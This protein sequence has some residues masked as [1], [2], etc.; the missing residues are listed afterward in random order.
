MPAYPSLEIVDLPD[1]V[2]PLSAGFRSYNPGLFS[3]GKRQFIAFRV[4]DHTICGGS[5]QRTRKYY[6]FVRI[7]DTASG[8]AV[9]VRTTE[10]P[11][12]PTSHASGHED[13]RPLVIGSEVWLF[14][15]CST[16]GAGVTRMYLQRITVKDLLGAFEDGREVQA[17][18]L[19]QLHTATTELKMAKMEKNWCPFVHEAT[20]HLVYSPKPHI[21]LKLDPATGMCNVVGKS[22]PDIPGEQRGGTNPLLIHEGYLSCVHERIELPHLHYLHR[23]VLFAP[24]TPFLVR[25]ISEAFVFNPDGKQS[26]EFASS[27]LLDGDDI[28]IGYGEYDCCAKLARIKVSEVMATLRAVDTSEPACWHEIANMAGIATASTAAAAAAAAAALTWRFGGN[29]AE[30]GVVMVAAGAVAAAASPYL[31]RKMETKVV[32]RALPSSPLSLPFCCVTAFKDLKR[33]EWKDF[34]RGIDV[35]FKAFERLL[36][37]PIPLV[38]FIDQHLAD[39]VSRLVAEFRPNCLGA[40]A[41]YTEVIPFDDVWLTQ[42]C[43]AR[44]LLSREREIMADPEYQGTVQHRLHHPEHSVPEYNNMMHCKVDFVAYAMESMQSYVR[45]GFYGW[46]DLGYIDSPELSVAAP[47]SV[48]GLP[49]DRV[50]YSVVEFPD[51]R[52]SDPVYTLRNAPERF[53]GGFFCGGIQAL[54]TYRDLYYATVVQFHAA[55]LADDDQSIA[56]NVYFQAPSLFNLQKRGF[57]GG[58]QM[59]KA[60]RQL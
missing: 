4:S 54:R 5:W 45:C 40:G 23:F 17:F 13:A 39:R 16:G 36:Q 6:S 26:V 19:V 28:L 20:V 37:T 53:A 51:V 42:N 8:R 9:T 14:T 24:S 56:I 46:V 21:I 43:P 41:T 25:G 38:I 31:L 27:A 60:A 35:Y 34:N 22:N 47:L 2:P 7:L 48:A 29:K 52:D 33:G 1:V 12:P 30:I 44:R 57:K 11:T 32:P 18:D 49:V 15:N 10:P 59:L 55:N 50:S 58:L 3:V